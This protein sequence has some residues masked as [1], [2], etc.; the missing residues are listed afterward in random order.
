M[1]FFTSGR[2]A[3]TFDDGI[4][5]GLRRLI[6]DPEFIYRRE[7]A[8]AEV[9]AGKA[10]RISDLALASRLS[11]FLWS[12]MPDDQLLT[13]AEQGRLHDPAHPSALIRATVA[14]WMHAKNASRATRCCSAS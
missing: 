8:P 6:A 12:S 1:E 5:K 9:S 10:Y 2:R 3:G 7:V 14:R 4:E 13:L 11:F